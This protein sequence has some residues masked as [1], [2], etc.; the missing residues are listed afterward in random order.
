[1]CTK[2]IRSEGVKTQIKSLIID[3][4]QQLMSTFGK[5]YATPL[6]MTR[7][8]GLEM[9]QIWIESR[10]VVLTWAILSRLKSTVRP[11][12]TVR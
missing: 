11:D 9:I 8:S 12:E 4:I 5:P 2:I 1:M 10:L 6:D 7:T 3:Q